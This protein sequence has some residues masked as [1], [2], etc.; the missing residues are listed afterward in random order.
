MN[1]KIVRF[2]LEKRSECNCNGC[3]VFILT[4]NTVS[5]IDDTNP[6][7]EN[8]MP[9]FETEWAPKGCCCDNS[10]TYNLTIPQ[11]KTGYGSIKLVGAPVKVNKCCGESYYNLPPIHI[12]RASNPNDLSIINR[13]DSRP[14]Y[15]TFEYIMNNH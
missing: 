5:R 1:A 11:T 15:R 10:I 3:E 13:H 2:R 6:Q 7:N 12:F 14:F 9:L 8:E 4:I